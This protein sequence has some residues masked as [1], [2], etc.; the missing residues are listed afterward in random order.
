[1]KLYTK[2]GD[3]GQTSLIGGRTRKD[4]S[5]VEAYGTIDEL[6]S[7]TGQAHALLKQHDSFQDLAGMLLVVQ[8]ELFD[9][10]TDLAYAVEG[11]PSKLAAESVDRLELWI[12]QLTDEASEITKFILPGGSVPS[13]QLHI[14]RTVCRRAERRAVTAAAEHGVSA[15]V[16]KYLNRLSD[17]FF[18]AA[19]I[20]NARLCEEDIAYERSADVFRLKKNK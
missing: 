20:A 7:F 1:M 15:D 4:D 17:F 6:N 3:K 10:G 18:A 13:S 19:R 12:D 14:C 8:H 2:G 9:C 11:A 5:R 16:I